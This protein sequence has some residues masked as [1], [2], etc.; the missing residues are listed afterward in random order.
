MA[1]TMPHPTEGPSDPQN[2]NLRMEPPPSLP[3]AES[4]ECV[5]GTNFLTMDHSGPNRLAQYFMSMCLDIFQ[6]VFFL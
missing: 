4:H 5:P 6:D 3:P 1:T 2:S